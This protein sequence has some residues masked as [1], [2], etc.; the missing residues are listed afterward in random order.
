ME[1]ANT[2]NYLICT[3]VILFCTLF[4]GYIQLISAELILEGDNS[5]A[6]S[7]VALDLNVDLKGVSQSLQAISESTDR[8]S[9]TLIIIGNNPELKA[10]D[11]EIISGLLTEYSKTQVTINTTVENIPKYIKTTQ[12]TARRIADDFVHQITFIIIVSG[13]VI[14][15]LIIAALAGFKYF[16]IT[17]ARDLVLNPLQNL[18][19]MAQALEDIR[20]ISQE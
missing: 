1:T 9:N 7:F 15:L 14:L 11:R 3:R 19:R 6:S 2:M 5:N 8:L 18:D 10:E 12:E 4:C 20:D 13:T 16:V 17:P